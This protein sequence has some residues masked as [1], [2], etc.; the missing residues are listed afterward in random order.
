MHP[1][2]PKIL[3]VEDDQSLLELFALALE[4]VGEVQAFSRA[5]H[6]LPHIDEADILVTDL[7]LPGMSGLELLDYIS[8]RGSSLPTLVITAHE[9]CPMM[10]EV[11][12]RGIPILKK[13][14]RMHT[15]LEMVQ[16]LQAV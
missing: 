5:V 12:R 10:K 9:G 11:L 8:S 1:E 4:Q 15:L 3:L 16:E 7:A 2:R 13:P 14:F 6:A